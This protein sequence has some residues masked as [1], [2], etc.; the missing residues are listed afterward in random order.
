MYSVGLLRNGQVI[1][2]RDELYSRGDYP[3]QNQIINEHS[4]PQ[5]FLHHTH[6][7]SFSMLQIASKNLNFMFIIEVIASNTN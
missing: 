5:T 2:Y 7:K 6:F 4:Q 1:N 3:F